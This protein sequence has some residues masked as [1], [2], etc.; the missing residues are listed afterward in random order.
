MESDSD[1]R[2]PHKRVRVFRGGPVYRMALWKEGKQLVLAGKDGLVTV[3]TTSHQFT[4]NF[5]LI[6]VPTS[7]QHVFNALALCGDS[8]YVGCE[9]GS[10]LHTVLSV[11]STPAEE[12]PIY[13]GTSAVLDLACS[14]AALFVASADGSVVGVDRHSGAPMWRVHLATGSIERGIQNLGEFSLLLLLLCS[15]PLFLFLAQQYF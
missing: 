10:V 13:T 3:D 11:G 12:A 4:V 14:D 5:P 7:A 1:A 8:S 15:P 6:R 2:I 9:D